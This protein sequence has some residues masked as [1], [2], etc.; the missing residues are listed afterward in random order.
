MY[1]IQPCCAVKDLLLLRDGLGKSGKRQFEGYGD[2]SLTELL[3]A[4]LARYSKTEMVIAA[5]SLPDQAT[6]IIAVWMR[7]QFARMEGPGKLNAIERMTIITDLSEELS[8]TAASWVKENPFGDRLTL[9]DRKQEDTVLLLPDI[10]IVGPVNMRYGNH[11]VAT[12]TTIREE[13]DELWMKY[14]ND[15]QTPQKEEPSD[16]GKVE[17]RRF[18]RRERRISGK[19]EGQEI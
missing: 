10:A 5:P 9:A 16:E 12:V 4:L 8:P 18:S 7:K 3:P 13:V 1:I 2:L 17:A 14:R 6:D 19:K 15:I 11:F